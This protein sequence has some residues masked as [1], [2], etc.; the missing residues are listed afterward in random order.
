[1]GKIIAKGFINKNGDQVE[2][3]P[4]AHTHTI[5]DVADL[6]ITLGEK[7]NVMHTHKINDVTNLNTKLT[8]I[9]TSILRLNENITELQELGTQNPLVYMEIKD[10]VKIMPIYDIF[11][12]IVENLHVESYPYKQITLI[13]ANLGENSYAVEEILPKSKDY[14]VTYLNG[15]AEQSIHPSEVFMFRIYDFQ[16]VTL[17]IT[18]ISITLPS[19]GIECLGSFS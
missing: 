1:M 10:K 6:Q 8:T 16:Y 13:L 4:A 12:Y 15:C 11:R 3:I 17:N 2:M 18:D 9:D 7:A 14:P 5:G 19:F